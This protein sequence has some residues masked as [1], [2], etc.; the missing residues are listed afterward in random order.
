MH[1]FPHQSLHDLITAVR[2]RMGRAEGPGPQ[3]YWCETTEQTIILVVITNISFYFSQSRNRIPFL[4][5]WHQVG[6]LLQ[7]SR[8][9]Q[10][11][12]CPDLINGQYNRK[13][14]LNDRETYILPPPQKK[15]TRSCLSHT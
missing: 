8:E 5:Q 9:R 2:F 3:I 15:P 10:A 7:V 14:P 6:S 13:Q 4:A 1:H 11:R 12:S